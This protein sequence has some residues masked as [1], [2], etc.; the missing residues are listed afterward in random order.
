MSKLTKTDEQWKQVLSDEQYYVLRQEGTERAN[1]SPLNQEKRDG[2][3]KC[4]GC[5]DALFD[6][7]TKYESGSGWPSFYQPA[8]QSA[9]TEHTDRK[10]FVKRTEVRCS[11]CDGHLGHVFPDGPQPTGQR[12]CMNGAALEFEPEE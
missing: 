11:N 4:A 1:S 12:Y 9:V 2:M 8:N 3:F 6:A 7:K 10:L 5:G